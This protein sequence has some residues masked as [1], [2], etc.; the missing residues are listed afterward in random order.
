MNR[1]VGVFVIFAV[2]L[3]LLPLS[4]PAADEI[5]VYVNGQET[6]FPDQ[7]PLINADN[8]TLVPVRFVSQALGASVGWTEASKTV[9]IELNNKILTLAIGKKEATVGANTITMDTAAALINE[10]TMVPLRFISEGLGARVE[11]N[12]AQRAI[13]ITTN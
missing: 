5:K 8:R 10:R 12:G 11:W 1:V 9:T 6:I 2:V 4:A 3:L 13:Y 7:K